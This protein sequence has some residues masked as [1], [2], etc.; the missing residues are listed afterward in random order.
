MQALKLERFDRG[1][2]LAEIGIERHHAQPLL[3]LAEDFGGIE[4]FLLEHLPQLAGQRFAGFLETQTF[5]LGQAL[6]DVLETSL[7]DFFDIHEQLILRS[8]QHLGR[9]GIGGPGGFFGRFFRGRRGFGSRFRPDRLLFQAAFRRLF[10][11]L[12]DGFWH[13]ASI[14]QMKGVNQSTGRPGLCYNGP[15]PAKKR[16]KAAA[17]ETAGLTT[18]SLE[19]LTWINIDAPSFASLDALKRRFPFFLDADL[20]ECLPPFQRPKLVVRDRYAFMVLLFPVFDRKSR[21]IRNAEI[22]F[23]IGDEF[24]V[25]THTP[26]LHEIRELAA[27]CGAKPGVCAELLGAG[28]GQT[29]VELVRLLVDSRFP[30]LTHLSND[31]DDVEADIFRK[32]DEATIR[33]LLRIKTNIVNFRKTMQGHQSVLRSLRDRVFVSAAASLKLRLDET[34]EHSLEMWDAIVHYK[35]AID[36][37]HE[38]HVS[39]VNVRTSRT[40]ETLTALALVIFP[41]TLMA[42]IFSMRAENMP[43]VGEPLDFWVMLGMIFSVMALTVLGLKWKKLM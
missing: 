10:S 16:K 27:N 20:R 21:I 37:L 33:E 32:Y 29:A 26:E 42:T 41:T 15:M 36:A 25:T 35:D 34:I 7:Q 23:F 18:T 31:V 43:F 24:I 11:G 39:L 9:D 1:L 38:S 14:P 30:M 19:G 2:L 28:A 12:F 13:K 8:R 17:P 5:I 6:E 40:S 22:D 4:L 3:L